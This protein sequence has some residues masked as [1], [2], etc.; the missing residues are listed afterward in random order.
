MPRSAP[1]A[2]RSRRRRAC[3]CSTTCSSRASTSSTHA[4]NR[5]RA[6][7][8]TSSFA[9]ASTRCR[10]VDRGRGR[11]A[12]SRVGADA[13]VAAVVPG[14]R[15]RREA[16]RRDPAAT[17]STMR[18]KASSGH[19]RACIIAR[20]L[21]MKWI[22]SREIAIAL[23]DAHPDVDPDRFRFTDLHALGLR[24]AG[25]RRRPEAQRRE[26]PRGDPVGLDRRSSLTAKPAV[27]FYAGLSP[28]AGSRDVSR[29][30]EAESGARRRRRLALARAFTFT[31]PECC[32]TQ[33]LLLMR[34]ISHQVALKA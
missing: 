34:A 12:R 3:R 30:A 15:R 26:D 16:R 14:D 13:A 28:A 18:R 2:R 20:E 31:Q 21:S 6:R 33:L 27:A 23:A 4:R 11:P 10:A 5:A 22:D 25:I 9:K 24:A 17:R 1:T 19:G 32:A 7:P 8:V 29:L